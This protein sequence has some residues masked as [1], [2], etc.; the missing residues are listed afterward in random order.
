MRIS[1]W[2][3][4]VCSSDL[5]RAACFLLLCLFGRFALYVRAGEVD[6]RLTQERGDLA[7]GYGKAEFRVIAVGERPEAVDAH[8]APACIDKGAAAVAAGHGRGMQD[9]IELP[10]TAPGRYGAAGFD[11]SQRTYP[12]LQLNPRRPAHAP[13]IPP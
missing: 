3:S 2:S 5:R 13:G 4:D 10:G 11:G 12:F 8:H 7:I 9:R 1:D 6:A